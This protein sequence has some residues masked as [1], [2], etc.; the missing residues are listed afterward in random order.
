MPQVH[1]RPSDIEGDR[2]RI[3][4]G[5]AFHLVRVLRKTV[6]DEIDVFDGAGR[7]F[8]ATLTSIDPTTPAADGRL[9][10]EI[11]GPSRSF[12]IRLYQGL[13]RGSK[14]DYVIEKASELG[15]D[16][17]VPFLSEK[18]PRR[19]NPGS[20][21]EGRWNRVAEAAAKQCNRPTIPEVSSPMLLQE[22]APRLSAGSTLLLTE[23][24]EPNS[25][26]GAVTAAL[27]FPEKLINIVIGPESGLTREETDLLIGGGAKPVRLGARTLRTET[28]GLVVLAVLN[29][30]LDFL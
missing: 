20:E 6:G 9:L 22:I 24:A 15:V 8:R 27:R 2:F 4:G 10:Q 11:H 12:E 23:R 30:E 29:Y 16:F 18:N 7:R 19:L 21:R 3:G 1:I 14:F 13:P 26:R 5:E 25:L 17:I 28:A